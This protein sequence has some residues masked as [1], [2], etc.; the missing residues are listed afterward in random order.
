[1]P[2]RT[3][4]A[5]I[6]ALLLSACQAGANKPDDTGQ[7]GKAASAI[8]MACPA[9][10]LLEIPGQ[11]ICD[12]GDP[13][14]L[15]ALPPWARIPPHVEISSTNLLRGSGAKGIGYT[16]RYNGPLA[17]IEPIFRAQIEH[18]PGM[19]LTAPAGSTM[20]VGRKNGDMSGTYLS[21]TPQKKTTGGEVV[22]IRFLQRTS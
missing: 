18:E 21:L 22:E 9:G 17:D 20:L 2:M 5:M 6:S 8:T 14:V 12:G 19:K 16:A 1:M 11:A 7:S 4:F 10:K 15:A 13:A 3:S